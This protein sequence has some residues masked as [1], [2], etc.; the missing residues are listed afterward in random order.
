MKTIKIISQ[1]FQYCQNKY[2]Y[3]LI[4]YYKESFGLYKL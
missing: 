1:T 3:N 4:F 2:T